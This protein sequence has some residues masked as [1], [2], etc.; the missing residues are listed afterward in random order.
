[1]LKSDDIKSMDDFVKGYYRSKKMIKEQNY[2]KGWEEIVDGSRMF[3]YHF[4]CRDCGGALPQG[5]VVAPR[6]CCFCGKDHEGGRR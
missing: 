6:Y 5:F 3:Q 2:G 1:M 4:V